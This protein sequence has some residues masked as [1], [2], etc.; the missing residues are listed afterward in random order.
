MASVT[1][2]TTEAMKQRGEYLLIFFTPE[3]LLER[4]RQLLGTSHY[5]RRVKAF[6]VDEAHT[7]K[8]WKVTNN[9]TVVHDCTLVIP[10]VCI[11]HRGEP[12]HGALL[13]I[14]EIRSLLPEG[15]HMMAMTATATRSL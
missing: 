13:R 11:Q 1:S 8:K 12:F 7:V 15:V 10:S 14:G 5:T 3:L 2:M 4:W 6:V 9:Y